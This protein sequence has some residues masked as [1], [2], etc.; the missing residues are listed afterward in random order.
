MGF[1]RK[2]GWTFFGR[3]SP[4][5]EETVISEDL[6]VEDDSMPVEVE[7]EAE[8][9][10]ETM[11]VT[12]ADAVRLA[13]DPIQ[14]LFS[15]LGK[16][17]RH[18][19]QAQHAPDGTEWVEKCM[20]ELA[21]GL[22]IAI[23]CE[24]TPVKDALIDTARILHSYDSVGRHRES[25][26]FLNSSYEILSL[27]VGDLIVD[28][29]RSGVIQK[30]K[31]LY[32]NTVESLEKSGIPLVQDEEEAE[33]SEKSI[34]AAPADAGG[35]K[36]ERVEIPVHQEAAREPLHVEE[37]LA[38]SV[39]DDHES[40][41]EPPPV[42]ADASDDIP[43]DLP[44]LSAME[45]DED[46]PQAEVDLAG[47]ILEFPGKAV[48]KH[49][50]EED[51]AEAEDR[52][53]EFLDDV[54]QNEEEVRSHDGE[55][56]FFDVEPDRESQADAD[57]EFETASEQSDLVEDDMPDMPGQPES[58]ADIAVDEAVESAPEEDSPVLEEE[59]VPEEIK[60]DAAGKAEQATLDLDVPA[61]AGTPAYL[62]RQAQDAMNKGD[63]G[64]ARSVAL[65]LA[66]AMARIEYEQARTSLASAEQRLVDNAQD[67]KAAQGQVDAAEQAL[68]Q[69]EDLL[70]TRDGESET[71]RECIALVDEE[72]GQYEADLA[73][74]DAEIE[75]LQ[76]KRAE[77]VRRIEDKRA[78]REDTINNESRLQTEMEA[79]REEVDAARRELEALRDGK[80]KLVADSR[81]I[82]ASIVAAKEDAESRSA[83]L[84]AIERTLHSQEGAP[85][86]SGPEE[87][88]LL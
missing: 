3:S 67:I 23:A 26:P 38:D 57:E 52:E 9:E 5:K 25:I 10:E 63:V 72:L 30:W 83:A 2:R 60:Q 84:A 27:M 1:S 50:V 51:G 76:R 46:G 81:E 82:K 34:A 79:L 20:N 69:T 77:Q 6:L 17:N 87:G 75:A 70:A 43:L 41:A 42:E 44:P 48:D 19:S 54:S 37:D 31:E 47:S 28:K 39:T 80:A 68:V 22:E 8:A 18:L 32:R 58:E 62:L 16:F 4:E 55:E 33:R 78:E 13:G 15:T 35:A 88:N 56:L 86:E 45:E 21:S 61:D 11:A 49:S 53:E 40:E 65:E 85:R 14:Y 73:G 7:T 29:V 71:C 74:I 36:Q 12:E 66:L 59:P 24:W 64:Q